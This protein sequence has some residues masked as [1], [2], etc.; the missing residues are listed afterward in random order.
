MSYTCVF[1]CPCDQ[2]LCPIKVFGWLVLGVIHPAMISI[3]LGAW[4]CPTL[5]EDTSWFIHRAKEK[6]KTQKSLLFKVCKS[7]W[8][9]ITVAQ[10]LPWSNDEAVKQPQLNNYR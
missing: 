9:V 8:V 10:I 5:V 6:I 1:H 4:D 2:A 3:V 7:N